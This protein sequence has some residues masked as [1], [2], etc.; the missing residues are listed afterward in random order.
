MTVLQASVGQLE[1]LRTLHARGSGI[2]SPLPLW[3]GGWGCFEGGV[4]PPIRSVFGRGGVS[5][6]NVPPHPRP[7]SP[8]G[9]REKEGSPSLGRVHPWANR[10]A[11][12]LPCADQFF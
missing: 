9:E 6:P 7:L 10:F 4:T 2:F 12:G 8:G 11:A 3:G 1:K 5:P